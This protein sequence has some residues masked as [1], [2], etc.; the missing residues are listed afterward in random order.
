MRF[1]DGSTHSDSERMLGDHTHYNEP[2][3]SERT[4]FTLEDQRV[5]ALQQ[6]DRATFQ[7]VAGILSLPNTCML[8]YHLEVASTSKC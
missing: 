7:C 6:V 5:I 3:P 8:K 1:T 4:A 2:P